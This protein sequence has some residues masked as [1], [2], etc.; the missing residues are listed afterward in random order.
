MKQIL[1]DWERFF[2]HFFMK[3]GF[4]SQDE[5]E[6]IALIWIKHWLDRALRGQEE[7]AL[8]GEA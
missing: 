7:G 2:Q 5:G 6:G 4:R 3:L 8:E 1:K